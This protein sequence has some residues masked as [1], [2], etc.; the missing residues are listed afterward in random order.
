MADQVD[1]NAPDHTNPFKAITACAAKSH[2]LL[3]GIVNQ[4]TATI[5]PVVQLIKDI[6]L[7]CES[8]ADAVLGALHLAQANTEQ[9]ATAYKQVHVTVLTQLMAARLNYPRD[10]LHSLM[11]AGLTCNVGMYTLSEQLQHQAGGLTPEQK[12]QVN[13]HPIDGV[14]M[15]KA[16]GVHR[17]D[18]LHAVLEHHER[19]D[20]TGYPRHL[21]GDGISQ[22]A[23]IL[24][25]AETYA[26][27]VAPRS[28]RDSL[29]A[30][31]ALREL[32]LSRS[33]QVDEVL[34]SQFI[35]EMGIFPPGSLVTLKNGETA[36]VTHR[37]KDSRAPRVS[38]ILDPANQ[39]YEQPL[40]RICSSDAQYA[41]MDICKKEIDLHCTPEA[42]WGYSQ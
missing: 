41:I 13:A 14:D 21:T 9:Y 26:A 12:E 7:L 10:R 37:S 42:L 18:W 23:R 22:G 6:R 8:N 28:Y 40:T 36:V 2:Q 19:M 31:D 16:V 4:V 27:M 25:L 34:A 39:P 20:G 38:S 32:F 1:N 5:P 29:L 11:C 24:A 33:K 30:K 3:T 15:L 17:E 35:K